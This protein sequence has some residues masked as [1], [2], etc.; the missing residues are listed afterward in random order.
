[1]KSKVSMILKTYFGLLKEFDYG[2]SITKDGDFIFNNLE[3]GEKVAVSSQD[4][5]KLYEEL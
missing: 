5:I 3:T 2:M 4:L 1:M